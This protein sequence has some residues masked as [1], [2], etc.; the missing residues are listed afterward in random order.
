[1]QTVNGICSNG[2][3][4]IK[5]KR[6]IRTPNIVINRFGNRYNIDAHGSK[7]SSGFLRTITTDA[8]HTINTQLTDMLLNK[9]R[10]V[11]IG[12]N[13][14]LFERFFTRSTQNSTALI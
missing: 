11:Y 1:M 3:S 4:R 2:H 7:L 12:R 9:G 6:E 5:A 8:H 14:L 13:A 10:L